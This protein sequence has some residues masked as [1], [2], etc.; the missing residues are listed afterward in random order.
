MRSGQR[1]SAIDV[2]SIGA[3]C[4]FSL[5][6]QGLSAGL[7]ASVPGLAGK[8]IESVENAC[9]SGGQAILS[10]ID[11]LLEAG[12]GEVGMAIG[13]EKMRDAEGKM[14]G[15]L[16]GKVLGLLLAPR[17]AAREGRTSSR[18]SSPEVMAAYM[19]HWGVTERR[20]RADLVIEYGNA[21]YNPYAQMQKV[22]ITLDQAMKLERRNRYLVEGLPLKTYDCSQITDGYAAMIIATEQGLAKLG[23]RKADTVEIAGYAQATDP[24]RKEGRDVLR[25]GGANRRDGQGLCDGRR[26]TGRRKRRRGARLLHGDGCD[27]RRGARQGDPGQGC[28]ATGWTARRPWAA[29]APSTPPAG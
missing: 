29:S 13:Y 12:D 5:N 8:P 2:A 10:V 18:T 24:L 22:Q 28:A 20:P 21:K 7:V 23:V 15:K 11:E 26:E 3:T 1:R 19:K 9:A 16:I 25:P 14:D 17:R 6:E 27:R 4:N